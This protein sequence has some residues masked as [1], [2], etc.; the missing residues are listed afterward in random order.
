LEA[1][2]SPAIREA[3]AAQRS[4]RP[5]LVEAIES[6]EYKKQGVKK[7][8]APSK[9]ASAKSSS[10]SPDSFKESQSAKP[11]KSPSK[12]TTTDESKDSGALYS[13]TALDVSDIEAD[14]NK[15]VAGLS[16]TGL[17]DDSV[18]LL[19]P[20]RT[21]SDKAMSGLRGTGVNRRVSIRSGRSSDFDALRGTTTSP[22]AD[23]DIAPSTGPD[24]KYRAPMLRLGTARVSQTVIP[25]G[26]RGL[27]DRAG[28]TAEQK[29]F[30]VA[31]P[32]ETVSN[33]VNRAGAS[34]TVV[35][36]SRK[37]ETISNLVTL[38][39]AAGGPTDTA[40][41]LVMRQGD[42]SKGE[43]ARIEAGGYVVP[44]M[45]YQD[46]YRETREGRPGFIGPRM[47]TPLLTRTGSPDVEERL[48]KA[49]SRTR[50][51]RVKGLGD[52]PVVDAI[53]SPSIR[54]VADVAGVTPEQAT[55]AIGR[56]MAT[57]QGVARM[58]REAPFGIRTRSRPAMP[59]SSGSGATSGEVGVQNVGVEGVESMAATSETTRQ[60]SRA[61]QSAAI[62]ANRAERAARLPTPRDATLR[63][64]PRPS[65]RAKDSDNTEAISNIMRGVRADAAAIEA[66]RKPMQVTPDMRIGAAIGGGQFAELTGQARENA[67][68]QGRPRPGVKILD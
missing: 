44:G 41:N 8:R 57:R 21:Y 24:Y 37:P 48:G 4:R 39:N 19:A 33:V 12:K 38:A 34:P 58:Q 17:A 40:R 66:S 49:G 2:P 43:P 28:T 31:R 61:S 16:A 53:V 7:K 51:F 56:Q 64:A 36:E 59:W 11:I 30:G 18:G 46:P 68:F 62:S 26:P 54:T 1:S 60:A 14:V 5:A 10:S 35:T 13:P 45:R 6:N 9:S 27:K 65:T 25:R 22:E 50:T 23:T 52:K 55:L 63:A 20:A 29:Y 47:P 42:P 67:L 32:L 15:E 3:A